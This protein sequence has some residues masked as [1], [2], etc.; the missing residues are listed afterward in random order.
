MPEKSLETAGRGG[1]SRRWL[2][3][4]W[5]GN[6]DRIPVGRHES[7]A[8]SLVGERHGKGMALELLH[9]QR[10]RLGQQRFGVERSP[11]SSV[12]KDRALHADQRSRAAQ[13]QNETEMSQWQS[14]RASLLLQSKHTI[15]NKEFQPGKTKRPCTEEQDR[16]GFGPRKQIYAPFLSRAGTA[17]IVF[18]KHGGIRCESSFLRSRHS[19]QLG[20]LV[21]SPGLRR[22]P[23][24]R[25]DPFTRRSKKRP[26]AAP[27]RGARG[28]G[29]GF[30][31]PQDAGALHAAVAI[32][33]GPGAT[34]HFA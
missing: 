1:P 29:P 14:P 18:R 3:D 33:I 7:A 23:F 20:L 5:R 2:V 27:V 28:G 10:V 31:A 21:R 15:L 11:L 26:A 25:R 32:G 19:A 17:I 12:S 6:R 30:A 4:P 13:H 9:H 8:V 16:R 22:Q 24:P 34:S